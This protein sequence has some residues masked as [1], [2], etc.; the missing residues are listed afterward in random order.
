M[1]NLIEVIKNKRLTGVSTPFFGLSW[2]DKEKNLKSDSKDNI[3]I[4]YK[5]R[6]FI[7]SI[8]GDRGRYD[9][10]RKSLKDTI[11]STGIA[12]VYLF[13]DRPGTTT[14]INDYTWSVEDSDVCIFIID[15]KD[16]VPKGVQNEID[17]ANRNGI[18]ALYYFCT[19]FSNEKTQLQLSLEGPVICS[20]LGRQVK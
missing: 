9:S 4:D 1:K 17:T 18:K 6:V 10:L 5:I 20:L 12:Q 2:E 13:G 8:C 3:Q 7:S 19:E 11:E 14:A 15:N 16:G